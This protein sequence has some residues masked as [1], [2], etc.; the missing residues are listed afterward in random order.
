MLALTPQELQGEIEGC[1]IVYLEAAACGLS[2]LATK[3]GGAGESVQHEQTGL[4]VELAQPTLLKEGLRKL[5]TETELRSSLGAAAQQR[6]R[7]DFTWPDKIA[8]LE[9]LVAGLS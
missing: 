2:A 8:Q 4:V 6:A 9:A 3:T 1:G 7:A 5:L